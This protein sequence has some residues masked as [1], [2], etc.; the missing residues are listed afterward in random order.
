MAMMAAWTDF[1][2][3]CS[4]LCFIFLYTS[5]LLIRIRLIRRSII[6]NTFR[7]G[8]KRK[9]VPTCCNNSGTVH[10]LARSALKLVLLDSAKTYHI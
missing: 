7:K 5:V 1:T 9:E 4:I 10:E 3:L 8:N 6:N 2:F